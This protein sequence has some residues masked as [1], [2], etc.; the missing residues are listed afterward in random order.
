MPF[1]S[2]VTHDSF[3]YL[4]GF[5][6][7]FKSSFRRYNHKFIF[8]KQLGTTALIKNVGNEQHLALVDIRAKANF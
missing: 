2:S 6:L 5:S 1:P 4:Y 7:P 3:E 8:Q